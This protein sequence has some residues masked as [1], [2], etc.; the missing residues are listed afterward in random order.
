[1]IFVACGTHHQ[2]FDRLVR[3]AQALALAGTESVVVQRGASRLDAPACEVHDEV[4]P[5]RFSAWLHEARIVVLHA[6]S[7]S[8][9]EARS[10][11]RTP[12]LV[13]R[14]PEHAEHVDDHQLRFAASVSAQARVAEPESLVDVV[15]RFVEPSRRPRS[16]EQRTAQRFAALLSS[17]CGDRAS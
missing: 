3:A 14:R 11:G 13:P 10:L 7:S 1:M 16:C 9:L 12:I 6:G 4:E 2:P 5:D 8:F 15:A 17:W